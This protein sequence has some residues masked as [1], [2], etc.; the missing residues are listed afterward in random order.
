[1][2][3]DIRQMINLIFLNGSFSKIQNVKLLL[4][5]AL[6]VV[7][8]PLSIVHLERSCGGNLIF[9]DLTFIESIYKVYFQCCSYE[10]G[11]PEVYKPITRKH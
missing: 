4:I 3:G 7:H 9:S 8:F 6:K 10:Q 5:Y 2:F 1:M 11:H